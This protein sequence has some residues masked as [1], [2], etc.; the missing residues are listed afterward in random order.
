MKSHTITKC[1]ENHSSVWVHKYKCV[2]RKEIKIKLHMK[3]SEREESREKS[4]FHFCKKW[5]VGC[6]KLR[7]FALQHI[8]HDQLLMFF[9]FINLATKWLYLQLIHITYSTNHWLILFLSVL[10]AGSLS[11]HVILNGGTWFTIICTHARH[12]FLSTDYCVLFCSSLPGHFFGCDCVSFYFLFGCLVFCSE[13]CVPQTHEYRMLLTHH[14]AF[15]FDACTSFIMTKTN[16]NN[17]RVYWSGLPAV[18]IFEVIFFI[19]IRCK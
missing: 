8:R 16:P 9:H 14:L 5:N 19:S 17:S 4:N 7:T 2:G 13:H 11:S 3:W 15:S 18:A 10:C 12:Y 1:K 6:K